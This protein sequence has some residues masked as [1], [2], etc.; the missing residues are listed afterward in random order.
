MARGRSKLM[1]ALIPSSAFSTTDEPGS[2]ARPRRRAF[3]AR[4]ASRERFSDSK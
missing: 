4:L 2:L 1:C 3:H